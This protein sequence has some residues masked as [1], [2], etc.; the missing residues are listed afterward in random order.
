MASAVTGEA[1]TVETER[2]HP[3]FFSLGSVLLIAPLCVVGS[4]IGTQLIV[5]LGITTNTSLIGALAGMAL[6]RLPLA[7]LTRYK[8]IH[9]QNLAQSAISASTFGAGNALLLPIGIPFVMGRPDL[10]APIFLGVFLAMLIDGFMLY[11]MFDSEV[12]PASGAWPPGVAAAEAI[13]AGDEGGR[14]LGVLGLGVLVGVAGN[15]V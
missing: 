1:E 13:R 8:S 10:V 3:A 2:A 4:I 5:T 15:W 14:K 9:V 11:R 6:G 7:F 12:F